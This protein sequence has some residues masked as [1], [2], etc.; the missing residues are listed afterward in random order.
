[1]KEPLV[2]IIVPIYKVPEKFLRKCIKSLRGQTLKNIEILLVDDGSPD[3]CGKICDEYA[4][5][6]ERIK[7]IHKRNGGL[8]AARNT[9][10]KNAQGKW[11][12]FVDG[13]DW[14]EADMCELMYA[15]GEK[16]K[17]DI[18]L[19]GLMKDYGK[20]SMEYKLKLVDGKVYKADECKWLQQQLLVYNA[21]IAFAYAKLIRRQLLIDNQIYHDEILKQGAEGLEFNLRLF[22]KIHSATFVK[23]S[24]YHYIYNDN[25]ISAS[26]DEAN[27]EFVISCFE[28]IRKFIDSSENK[29]MLIPW[30]DNRLLYVIVTTAISGYFNPTNLEPYKDKKRKYK[31]YLQKKIVQ[32]ALKTSNTEGIGREREIILFLIKHRMFLVINMLGKIRKMQKERR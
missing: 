5:K 21:N 31:A 4:D 16:K 32:D 30:F 2:S 25:S 12:M 1:M 28:K 6:D 7:V 27:H 24:L 3:N 20:T 19:S 18:V 9:G 11:I 8:S 14:I 29:D 22:E 26:H 10:C 23:K 13:D 17:V 15:A